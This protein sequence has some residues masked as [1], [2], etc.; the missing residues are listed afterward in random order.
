MAHTRYRGRFRRPL[1]ELADKL[2][3]AVDPVVHRTAELVAP[4]AGH[5]LIAVAS[6]S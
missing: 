2:V 1:K 6:R 5:V 4:E 3:D